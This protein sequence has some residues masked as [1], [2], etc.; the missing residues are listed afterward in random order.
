MF[1]RAVEGRRAVS[2]LVEVRIWTP[3]F[4]G[5]LDLLLENPDG[6]VKVGQDI[7]GDDGSL[8]VVE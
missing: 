5:G 2:S 3:R 4:R 6:G 8:D 7:G 1:D